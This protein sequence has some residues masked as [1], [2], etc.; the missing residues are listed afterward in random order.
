VGAN[1]VTPGG[2]RG[3]PSLSLSRLHPFIAALACGHVSHVVPLCRQVDPEVS[4]L[5]ERFWND[6]QKYKSLLVQT[7]DSLWR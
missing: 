6:I 3:T 5:E 7:R 1:S 4:E 2:R